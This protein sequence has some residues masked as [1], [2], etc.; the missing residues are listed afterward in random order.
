MTPRVHRF[1]SVPS[2]QD[3]VHELAAD[4]A[5]AGTAVLA[6]EQTAGRGRRGH[7]WVSPRG[8]LWLSV[9]CRPGTPPALEVLSLR[10]ALRV[11]TALEA[12]VP[13][14]R[15][16]IKWPNDLLL[17]GRKLGGILCEA[18]WQG[19]TPVWVAVGLGLNV[20]NPI[21]LELAAH[22]ISLA[23]LIPGIVPDML[24]AP[25]I[26]A[27]AGAGQEGGPLTPAEL[28]GYR[29]RDWLLGRPLLEPVKGV[30]S[31]VEPDGAL[32]IQQP[33]GGVTLARSGTVLLE[34]ER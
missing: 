7:G 11:A 28:T 22:A 16:L 20:S 6:A 34:R 32:R 9:L 19:E 21:P 31:G 13:G 15:L 25:L 30:A 18:R 23:E 8:G 3:L 2:T 12:A 14:G 33:D 1:D 17:G 10:V 26:S 27:I 4:G 29:E 5:P 24:V